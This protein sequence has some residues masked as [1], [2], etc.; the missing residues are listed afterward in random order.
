MRKTLLVAMT[1]M[2]PLFLKAQEKEKQHEAGVTFSSLNSFGLTYRSG[3]VGA[4]WRF[5]TLLATGNNSSTEQNDSTTIDRAGI[6]IKLSVGREWRKTISNKVQVRYGADLQAGFSNYTQETDHGSN[7]PFHTERIDKAK[8]I[9]FNLVLG[10][11]YWF[12]D[13]LFVGA[14][15][16]P[17]FIYSDREYTS[18]NVSYSGPDPEK[19][20]FTSHEEGFSYGLSSNTALLSVGVKF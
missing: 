11:N 14:E 18:D 8:E 20:T 19:N 3:H 6:G 10:V 12:T 16:L 15:I 7:V 17:A 13:Q 1:L 5:N 2:A 9:G 4:L